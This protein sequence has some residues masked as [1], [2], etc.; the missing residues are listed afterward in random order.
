[1][2]VTHRH[3]AAIVPS[4]ICS[5]SY[6]QMRRSLADV[7]WQKMTLSSNNN[8]RHAG[9]PIEDEKRLRQFS[10]PDRLAVANVQSRESQSREVD[11]DSFVIRAAWTTRSYSIGDRRPT[12]WNP[13]RTRAST[14]PFPSQHRSTRLRTSTLQASLPPSPCE[15]SPGRDRRQADA[16]TNLR[17]PNDVLRRGEFRRSGFFDVET[18]PQFGP[19]NCGQ[20][21]SADQT[22]SKHSTTTIRNRTPSFCEPWAMMTPSRLRC[23]GTWMIMA[24]GIFRL[25]SP[26]S[27]ADATNRTW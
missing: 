21:S 16:V 8:R 5:P 15:G 9:S 6:G 17:R 4:K 25:S 11:V 22:C 27:Q 2:R 13:D 19:R 18:P 1:M 26:K 10:F 12:E 7:V 3:V 24:A 20:S 23:T 14:V